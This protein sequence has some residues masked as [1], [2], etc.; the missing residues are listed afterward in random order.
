LRAEPAAPDS[1]EYG[2]DEGDEQQEKKDGCKEEIK[3]PDPD[4][5]AEEV[6]LEFLNVKPQ[7]AV[8]VQGEKR[9]AAEDQCLQCLDETSVFSPQNG[10]SEWLMPL[11]AWGPWRENSL[12][13]GVIFSWWS[14]MR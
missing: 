8:A 6:E 9:Q 7:Y 3:L 1:A 13:N 10:I 2:G 4:D 11:H 12:D 14:E 5:G